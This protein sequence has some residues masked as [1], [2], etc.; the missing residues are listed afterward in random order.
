MPVP[1][2]PRRPRRLEPE[3]ARQAVAVVFTAHEEAA[4]RGIQWHAANY[5]GVR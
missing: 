3:H 4:S 5:V 2:A 1:S